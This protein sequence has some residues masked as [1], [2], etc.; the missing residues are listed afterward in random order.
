MPTNTRLTNLIDY[1]SVL[2][3]SS[4]IFGVYQPLLGWKGKRN[5]DRFIKRP[6]FSNTIRDRR[7]FETLKAKVVINMA[8]R[9]AAMMNTGNNLVRE[10]SIFTATSDSSRSLFADELAKL[11]EGRFDESRANRIFT[12][13]MFDEILQRTAASI[14]ENYKKDVL[15]N[16]PSAYEVLN[17]RAKQESIM[18]GSLLSLYERK[19][20]KAVE[21]IIFSKNP[22][23]TAKPLIENPFESFDPTKELDRVCLS[24]VGI[25]HLFRQYFYELDTF[26]GT[27]VGHVW[28]SP[29]STVELIESST[30]REI[31]EKTTESFVETIVKNESTIT[32]KDEISDAVK[33]ENENNTKFGA[34][35]SGEQNWVWGEAAQSASFDMG[36]TQK[37]AREKSHKQMREQTTKLSSEIRKNFKSTFKTVTEVTDVS[38][39]RMVITNATGKLLN[40]ELRRKMRQVAVQ[41]QDI[42]TYLC[43]QT[44]VDEPGRDLGLANLVHIAKKPDGD[45]PKAPDE[46]EILQP[47]K[48]TAPLV[49]PY[50]SVGVV[51]DDDA[52]DEFYVV[53][54][55]HNDELIEDNGDGD[56]DDNYRIRRFHHMTM[57]PDRQGYKLQAVHVQGNSN[58]TLK[59]EVTDALKGNFTVKLNT[60]HF[61]D[62]QS[63]TTQAEYEWVVCDA[64]ESNYIKERNKKQDEKVEAYENEKKEQVKMQYINAARERIKLASNI[65]PR[66]YEELREEERIIVY[67]RLIKDLGKNVVGAQKKSKDTDYH[68][69]S[70]LLNSIFDINKM[71]YFVAPEW[72]KA[73]EN[74]R[75]QMGGVNA[76][77][78]QSTPNIVIPNE[79]FVSWGTPR[80]DNYL[81][82]EDSSPAKMGSSLGWLLQ[83]DGDNLRNAFL[84][85]PWVKAVI[86]IRP[87][88][89]KEALNWLK[90]VEGMNGIGPADMYQGPEPEHQGKTIVKV[91]DELAEKVKSKHKDSFTTKT[92]PENDETETIDDRNIVSATPVDRVY[93]HGFY[94][95]QG[96][97][98]LDVDKEFQIFDQWVEILPTDQVV[99]VEVEYDPKTGRQK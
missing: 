66:K 47:F 2:P 35:V 88:K 53:N 25:V 12:N 87:G 54:P 23:I 55:K 13:Q 67:R 75:L 44:Y 40:Y 60:I 6:D 32:N 97:F 74:S 61:N 77:N 38:S 17:R 99:P 41:V 94:P 96:G 33:E 39:K 36:T 79:N 50:I 68:V 57:K 83:L 93:E 78:N 7:F 10:L 80:E 22:F 81:I 45:S 16:S 43:W 98:R 90:H 85:S 14:L 42:G 52:L 95:L 46:L 29:G 82:T 89:E 3:Y 65:L 21:D 64:S 4:E 30:R 34:N 48:T 58:V 84:N 18:A 27:P 63:V 37:T 1:K 28:L 31:V 9:P 86:P 51:N 72:W 26:L 76:E 24:P 69:F 71:L 8:E 70:E 91:L 49:I 73:R 15:E 19:E 11:F 92:F 59:T 5:L 56:D 62:Q 20:F